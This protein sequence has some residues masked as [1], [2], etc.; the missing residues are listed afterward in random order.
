MLSYKSNTDYRYQALSVLI[1]S[2]ILYN[3]CR[4]STFPKKIN[5]QLILKV[6]LHLEVVI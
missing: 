3:S 4:K 2:T 5:K 1:M 6:N